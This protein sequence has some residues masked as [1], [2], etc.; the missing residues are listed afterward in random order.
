MEQV[1]LIAD[2]NYRSEAII[3]DYELNLQQVV[4]TRFVVVKVRYEN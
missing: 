1:Q 3:S 2:Y 4:V